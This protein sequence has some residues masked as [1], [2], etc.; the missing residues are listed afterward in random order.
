[1]PCVRANGEPLSDR[2]EFENSYY[3]FV[4][5]LKAL[6]ASADEKVKEYGSL[7]E[8]AA[9]ELKD[10]VSAGIYLLNYEN[11]NLSEDQQKKI[12]EFVKKL[13]EVPEN[14]GFE[15]SSWGSLRKEAMELLKLLEP[16][17][18]ANAEYF[19]TPFKKL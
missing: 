3:Y 5:A 6:A 1:M 4:V 12:K 18:R 7:D 15:N 13:D 8:N 2:E 9:W 17:T 14:A 10:D 11:S 16:V 19:E